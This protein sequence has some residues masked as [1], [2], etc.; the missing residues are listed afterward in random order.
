MNIKKE[1]KA[2]FSPTWVDWVLLVLGVSLLLLGGRYIRERQNVAQPAVSVEYLLCLP[3]VETN[4]L[5]GGIEG[6]ISS[7]AS[8]TTANGTASLGKVRRVWSE[9]HVTP[10]VKDGAI[11]FTEVPNRVDLYVSVAAN[12]VLREGDGLRVSDIRIAA[13]CSGDFRIGNYLANGARVVSVSKGAL[14]S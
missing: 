5:D 7:D 8:V 13:G 12:A 11:V 3:A 9:A 4:A 2:R 1:K 10:T 14:L 6:L